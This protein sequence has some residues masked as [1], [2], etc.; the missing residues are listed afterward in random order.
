[1][2]G[3][4]AVNH[5]EL[6][7][8]S[9]DFLSQQLARGGPQLESASLGCPNGVHASVDLAPWGLKMGV[10]GEAQDW[11][12][13]TNA[14]YASVNYLY[15]FYSTP[16]NASWVEGVAWPWLVR[17]AA[18]WECR[19][20]KTPVAGAPDGYLYFDACDCSG[21]EGCKVSCD[22]GSRDNPMWYAVYVRRLLQGLI[23]MAVAVGKAPDVAW[24]DILAHMPPVPTTRTARGAPVL[25]W[26]GG[27][28]TNWDGQSNNLHALWPGELLGLSEQNATLLDA[29]LGSFN[30]TAWTQANSFNWVHSAAARAG[31]PPSGFL[32]HWH[33]SLTA[34]AR[35]NR[36]IAWSGACS[37][38][39]G[40]AQFPVDMLVQW[41]L[42]PQGVA[43]ALGLH[44]HANASVAVGAPSH[45]RLFPAW[46][47]NLTASFTQLRMRGALLVSA[48]YDPS[49]AAARALGP[50]ASV[51]SA[52]AAGLLGAHLPAGGAGGVTAVSI[53]SEAGAPV[54]LLSPWPGT[55][56]ASILVCEQGGS[57]G[58][59]GCPA[60]SA[61]V[62]SVTWA[63]LPGTHGGDLLA[64][65]T[66][67]G[68]RYEVILQASA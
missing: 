7:T 59:G 16:L 1:M 5:P 61:P 60:G 27:G 47:S 55:P 56:Q 53:T 52:V 22:D 23:D 14:A 11:G 2:A 8:P 18:F 6:A 10:W 3:A 21:D 24:T 51:A 28:T 68:G 29:A 50:G 35:P 25:A 46:P 57:G 63:Q 38:T 66:T 31:V 19:L 44:A 64:W 45:L 67:A 13:L 41:N 54:T 49:A 43:E 37:D 4:V 9:F 12:I 62:A 48:T 20:I 33:A 17:T 40:A 26:Y 32:S 36:L 39:L 34:H 65:P 15:Q 58:S 30:L 42:L